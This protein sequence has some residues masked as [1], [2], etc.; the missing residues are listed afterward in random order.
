MRGSGERRLR[1]GSLDVPRWRFASGR[2]WPL[3]MGRGHGSW[4]TRAH[5]R[6]GI[7]Q[8]LRGSAHSTVCC[9]RNIGTWTHRAADPARIAPVAHVEF[10][11]HSVSV[12]FRVDSTVERP[13]SATWLYSRSWPKAARD[14]LLPV[15]SRRSRRSGSS[16]CVHKPPDRRATASGRPTTPVDRSRHAAA[17]R[18]TARQNIPA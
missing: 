15:E 16:R 3:P 9:Q 2:S 5:R 12:S 17:D 8:R 1:F 14:S 13:L 11:E 7:T 6:V 18:D 4:I 10:L